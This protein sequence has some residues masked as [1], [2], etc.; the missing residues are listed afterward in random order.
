MRRFIEKYG[1]HIIVGLSVGGHDVVLVR[2]DKSSTLE[3]S[4]LKNHL[5]ELGDQLF[6]GA[7]TFPPP[8]SKPKDHHHKTKVTTLLSHSLIQISNI[9][10]GFLL[11]ILSQIYFCLSDLE[12]S[13]F[14]F[15]VMEIWI[16]FFVSSLK[17]Q[18]WSM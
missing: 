17:F 1:T 14:L 4:E 2:Q 15:W 3:A 10:F 13:S 16:W 7:C 6:N 18:K 9:I 12:L 5:E 11:C 8:L